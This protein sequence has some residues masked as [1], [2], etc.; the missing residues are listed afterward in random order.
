MTCDK[1]FYIDLT[2]S[3]PFV[4]TYEPKYLKRDLDDAETKNPL[5]LSDY[6]WKVFLS[7]DDAES[8]LRAYLSQLKTLSNSRI[9]RSRELPGMLYKRRYIV[10][11][12]MKLKNQ[13]FRSYK[14]DWKS[15]DLVNL[16]DQTFFL[17]V[18]I[19]KI[20]KV[21]DEW[22]YDFELAQ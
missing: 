5:D 20:T 9:C 2:D 21:D 14:R 15:G 7:R 22:R 1:V 10:Q 4:S 12:I 11:S 13:T 19:L 17:T 6:D 3:V 18:R 8:F 16:H